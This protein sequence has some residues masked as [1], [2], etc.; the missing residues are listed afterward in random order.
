MKNNC[1]HYYDF[2]GYV[3]SISVMFNNLMEL[4]GP[5]LDANVDITILR[6]V[7]NQIRNGEHKFANLV[8]VAMPTT[9]RATFP[10]FLHTAHMVLARLQQAR[11]TLD[12]SS[13]NQRNIRPT[14]SA[15]MGNITS[16]TN[17]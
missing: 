15:N 3:Q 8:S 13:K 2:K 14:N 4:Y 12:L 1:A 10:M 16:D 7:R 17:W 5:N 6:H 9:P 11:A